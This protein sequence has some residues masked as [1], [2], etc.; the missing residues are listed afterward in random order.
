VKEETEE[1]I[2]KKDENGNEIIIIKCGDGEI[3]LGP[4]CPPLKGEFIFDLEKE[5]KNDTS[6]T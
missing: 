6:P 4:P 3:H 1:M 5:N 2:I